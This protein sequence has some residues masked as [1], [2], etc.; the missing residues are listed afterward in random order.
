[1][2]HFIILI[3]GALFFFI[4]GTCDAL[5]QWTDSERQELAIRNI[6]Q[7]ANPGFENGLAMWVASGASPAK[8]NSGTNL[9]DDKASA[10]WNATASG[11]WFRTKLVTIPKGLYGRN[12]L[13][14]I[15]TQVPSG[16]A[17][18][19]IQVYDGTNIIASASMAS[20]TTPTFQD[21]NFIFPSSG[22]IAI[23]A[24]AQADEPLTVF[25]SGFIGDAINYLNVAQAEFVGSAY[26]TETST[27]I[28][29]R[30]NTAMGAFTAIAACPGPT[31]EFQ[32][33]GQW[34]TTDSDLPR[35]TINNLPPGSYHVI[36]SAPIRN[37]GSS[38]VVAIALTD[39]TTTSTKVM[40]SFDT[41][42]D[43]H[44]SVTGT[45]VFEYTTTGNRTF[46]IY[47]QATAN[48]V[49]ILN[50]TAGQQTWIKVYRYP[51]QS[52]LA[53]KPD[54]INW[55]VDA[56]ISGANPSLGTGSV[57]SYTEITDGSLTMTRNTGSAPVGIPC[58]STNPSVVGSLTCSAGSEGLGVTFNVPTAGAYKACADFTA[59]VQAGAAASD[60]EQAFQLVETA[61]SAQTILQ[62]GKSRTEHRYNNA[63]SLYTSV[64][65]RTCGT[66]EFGSSGQKTIRLMY[67][68]LAV[69]GTVGGSAVVADG[70]TSVGQRD[71]H[72][73][74]EPLNG[75]AQAAPIVNSVTSND[76]GTQR[77]ENAQITN[78]GATCG[79]TYESGD[80]INGTP[81][82]VGNGQCTVAISSGIW[83]SAPSC[84]CSYVSNTVNRYCG[85]NTATMSSSTIAFITLDAGGTAADSSF[86]VIC[87][88][89]R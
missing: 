9:L 84:V 88:G 26:F 30:T 10:T 49:S 34:Q 77:I 61:S 7:D 17:T 69:S 80:W 55:R 13:A 60:L 86:N 83:S 12:G 44:S 54:A 6:L 79:V 11:E 21:V 87:M 24:Y 2:K 35:F 37:S 1:M 64:P 46:E 68:Q 76:P 14:R 29:P 59:Y 25:D 20:T 50:E 63:G 15:K 39:G 72:V 48:T 89:P 45:A 70:S 33:V 5:A 74:V 56:N 53:Q 65:F 67:E 32:K 85:I 82:R 73:T 41:A 75:Q 78:N 71:F 81:S 40:G 36:F 27:C 62:E 22:S 58:S 18:T 43:D 28:W 57:S 38:Q 51:L 42:D 47:G 31:V 3:F 8:V 19:L 4:I 52:E 23:R 66:F 16:T